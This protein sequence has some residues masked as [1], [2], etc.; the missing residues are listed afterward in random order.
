MFIVFGFYGWGTSR[1]SALTSVPFIL[2]NGSIFLVFFL[3][4]AFG[5][6][7][8]TLLSEH[9]VIKCR[10]IYA[11]FGFL[12]LLCVINIDWIFRT[13]TGDEVAYALQSQS[14][15]YVIVKKILMFFPQ[16]DSL[17]F[18]LLIQ[19]C[20]AVMLVLFVLTMGI[21]S[22]IRSTRHFISL[23]FIGTVILRIATLSQGGSYGPNPP[24][25]SF[26]YLIGSTI[27]SP[28][29]FSYRILSLLLAS[30]FLATLYEYL[31]KI[32]RLPEYVR[33]L[34]LAF[35]ISFPIFRHMRL[36]VEISIW[37]FYFSST[38]LLQLYRSGGI[39]SY[40]QVFLVSIATTFRFPLVAIL[41]PMF[42][43]NVV[44]TIRSRKNGD[45]KATYWPSILAV[46]MCLPV[47]ILVS[48]T[49]LLER[50]SSTDLT[51]QQFS[52]QFTEVGK[53]T[54]EI[55]STLLITTSK[56]AWL[57]SVIGVLLYVRKSRIR[58]V[59]L[60]TY[61]AI[62]YILYFVV[63]EADIANRSKY[64]IEWFG[65][66]LVLGLIALIS[67]LEVKKT[68]SAFIAVSL[69]LLVITNVMEYNTNINK[70]IKAIPA[71]RAGGIDHRALAAVPFPYGAAFNELSKHKELSE[72]LNVGIVYGVYPQIMAGYSGKDVL[73]SLDTVHKYLA[74]QEQIHENWAT[75]SAKSIGLSGSNCVIVGHVNGQAS[76]VS[77]LLENNWKI[78]NKF[79]DNAYQTDVFI[80]TR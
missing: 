50:F 66:L 24:G 56:V 33:I 39:A 40:Q 35:I 3:F 41:V 75:S 72:C 46:L 43:T 69:T 22:K 64:I 67:S 73:A 13:L 31:K 14:Q 12:I 36:I 4:F 32:S 58:A 76:I 18:R 9:L 53:T 11:V 16:L 28:T 68:M 25:A 29:N 48:S 79:T 52:S 63:I 61:L 38:I 37:A 27:L 1:T 65:P 80:L 34:I 2:I 54:H 49:R 15:S 10:Q 17:S 7:Y 78:R 23:C 30:L 44:G 42:V 70:F 21:M 62:Q 51:K 26:Y 59:F 19:I 20:S 5:N 8:S 71:F 77:D 45:Q 60:L 74:A 57:I 6:R 55:F 47:I